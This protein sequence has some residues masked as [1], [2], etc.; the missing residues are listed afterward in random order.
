[1]DDRDDPTRPNSVAPARPRLAGLADVLGLLLV[2]S[3]LIVLFGLLSRNFW[4]WRTLQSVV[5]QVPDL[6]VVAAGMTLVVIAGGSTSRSA[7]CWRSGRRAGDR[8]GRLGWP[9]WRRRRSA[10]CRRLCGFLT[11]R[12]ASPGRSP[13]SS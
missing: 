13:R 5:N 7:R 9:L 4:T 3:A 2:L 8:H 11:E 12:S 1:M 10:C 6:M